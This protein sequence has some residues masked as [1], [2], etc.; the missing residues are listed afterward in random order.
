MERTLGIDIGTKRVGVAVSEGLIASP[1]AIYDRAKGRA[2]RE[3][4]DYLRRQEI[5]KVVVGMPYRE[6]GSRGE[7]CDEVDHFC[8][9]LQ[10]RIQ[11]DIIFYDEYLSSFEAKEKRFEGSGK[12][13]IGPV[14]ALAAAVILQGYLESR[15]KKAIQ[16]V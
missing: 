14:D 2:V 6:D 1:V 10:R 7:T 16:L 15:E 3:I 9:R 8:R 13:T 5:N 12:R 4:A 11:C